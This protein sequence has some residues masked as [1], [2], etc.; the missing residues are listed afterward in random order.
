MHSKGASCSVAAFLLVSG[1]RREAV[2]TVG[3]FACLEDIVV[4]SLRF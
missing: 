3:Q 2:L 4:E 1:R